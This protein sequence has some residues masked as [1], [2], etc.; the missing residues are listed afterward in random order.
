MELDL[1]QAK[2]VKYLREL[3]CTWRRVSE[4]FS[5]IYG[6][7]FGDDQIF[8]KEICSVSSDMLGWEEDLC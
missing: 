3:G 2:I 7:T 4:I 1:I 5:D 8:G 6:L